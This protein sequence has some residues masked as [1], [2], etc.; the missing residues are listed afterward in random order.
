MD[1][2]WGTFVDV[3]AVFAATVGVATSLAS[4]LFKLMRFGLSIRYPNRDP[5]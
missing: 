1:G 3:F 4:V 2:P 5:G